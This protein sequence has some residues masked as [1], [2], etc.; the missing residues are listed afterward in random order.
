MGHF[1]YQPETFFAADQFVAFQKD[2]EAFDD[3]LD[4][5]IGGQGFVQLEVRVIDKALHQ[6]QGGV[7]AA[8]IKHR[9]FLED[10]DPV[11][12]IT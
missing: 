4:V 7:D 8:V 2:V 12:W 3:E 1:I 5:E 11:R 9:S 10:D 6:V